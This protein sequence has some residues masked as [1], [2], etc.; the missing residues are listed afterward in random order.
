MWQIHPRSKRFYLGNP[1]SIRIFKLGSG[2]SDRI[3]ERD[4]LKKSGGENDERI[5]TS[6]KA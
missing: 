6:V 1:I 4:M 5:S 2:V 3:I